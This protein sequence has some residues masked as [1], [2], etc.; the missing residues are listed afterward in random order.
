[1]AIEDEVPDV[2]EFDRPDLEFAPESHHAQAEMAAERGEAYDPY[3]FERRSR[4]QVDRMPD[5]F[6]DTEPVE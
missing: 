5:P 4:E 1:V 3:E 2:E 6:E